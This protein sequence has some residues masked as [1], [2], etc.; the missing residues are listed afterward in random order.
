MRQCIFPMMIH[1]IIPTVDYK[2]WL[3]R[4]NHLMNQPINIQLKSPKPT[5]NLGDYCKNSPNLTN[6]NI[7]ERTRQLVIV[8]ELCSSVAY[9]APT[10]SVYLWLRSCGRSTSLGLS[11]M[12]T[13]FLPKHKTVKIL[14]SFKYDYWNT[15]KYLLR[16]GFVIC[17][18][19]IHEITNNFL[20]LYG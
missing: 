10:S 18:N 14:F 2:E 4:L 7:P 6:I 9:S 20:R 3:K 13:Q 19:L 8:E 16:E 1:K 12:I 5:N 15:V 11:Q 17:F